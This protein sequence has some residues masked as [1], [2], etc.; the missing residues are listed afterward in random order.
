MHK[1]PGV[2]RLETTELINDT[3]L[4]CIEYSNNIFDFI[5]LVHTEDFKSTFFL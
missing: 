3:K 5:D 1:C 2:K 4:E